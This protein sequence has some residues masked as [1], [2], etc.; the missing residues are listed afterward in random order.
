MRMQKQIVGLALIL[1]FFAAVLCFT[2]CAPC[3][4]REW[5]H[6]ATRAKSTDLDG[7][8]E[9]R[10][11]STTNGHSGALRAVITPDGPGKYRALFHA[12]YA[13]VLNFTYPVN[14]E[15]TRH[16]SRVDFCGAS[17]LPAWAGGR[18]TSS[19]RATRTDFTA[20]YQSKYDDGRFEMKRVEPSAR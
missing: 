15:T 17:E 4:E 14:F 20:N 3:F 13:S 19:G 2:G 10:W 12:T 9:G 11:I 8:W 6:A 18:Y 1:P 16:R 7:R 5:H